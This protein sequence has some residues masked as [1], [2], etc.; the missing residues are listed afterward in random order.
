MAAMWGENLTVANWVGAD[1]LGKEKRDEL[2]TKDKEKGTV[3]VAT[4]GSGLGKGWGDGYQGDEDYCLG[5]RR[6]PVIFCHGNRRRAR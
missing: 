1:A 2:V 3:A 4:E 5:N 6:G